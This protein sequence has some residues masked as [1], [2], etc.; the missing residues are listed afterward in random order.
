MAEPEQNN[1]YES[2]QNDFSRAGDAARQAS[3][4]PKKAVR[5]AKT[6]GKAAKA[7]AKAAG[8]AAKATAKATEKTAQVT[9]K[10]ISAVASAL[11]PLG[12]AIVSVLLAVLIVV[13][14]LA[15]YQRQL[16]DEN[17]DI[18]P[19]GK[20]ILSYFERYVKYGQFDVSTAEKEKYQN[21]YYAV[22]NTDYQ[23]ELCSLWKLIAYE[24]VS[25][26]VGWMQTNGY[27]DD[28]WNTDTS[29]ETGFGYG[30][31]AQ[32]HFYSEYL[33]FYED[34]SK[35][36]NPE[37]LTKCRGADGSWNFDDLVTAYKN[38]ISLSTGSEETASTSLANGM[39]YKLH[40]YYTNSMFRLCLDSLV[41]ENTN[42]VLE[43]VGDI[44]AKKATEQGVDE[45]SSEYQKIKSDV[46]NEQFKKIYNRACR[47]INS[48]NYKCTFEANSSDTVSTYREVSVREYIGGKDEKESEKEGTPVYRTDT[49]TGTTS[50]G[51]Y[52]RFVSTARGFLITNGSAQEIVQLAIQQIGNNYEPYCR[53]MNGGV[54]TDWCAFFC[55][56]LLKHCNVDLSN[57]GYAGGCTTWANQANEKGIWRD[58]RSGYT[59]KA[60]DFIF[61][62][63]GVGY[64]YHVGIVTY[65]EGGTITTVEG[66]SGSSSASPY[67]LGSSVTQNTYSTSSDSIAGYISMSYRSTYSGITGGNIAFTSSE[68]ETLRNYAAKEYDSSYN[69]PTY[70][71]SDAE[72]KEVARVVTGEFGE[73]K[74][75][76]MLIA[77]CIRDGLYS[78]KIKRSELMSLGT[79]GPRYDAYFSYH[80]EPYEDAINAVKTIF[81]QG[82]YVVHHKILYMYATDLCTSEWH[83]TQHFILQ[84]LTTRFF[85]EW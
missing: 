32:T 20:Q 34:D 2:E 23:D 81:M 85:D 36:T 75:G 72:I 73:D 16:V 50:D 43:S 55:G 7:T 56:W 64:C 27:T 84:H 38:G 46:E 66:N 18:T 44:V 61:W 41:D 70:Q 6:T 29:A 3:E 83:E 48:D 24:N 15:R 33:R 26:A 14:A 22:E 79:A 74:I 35:F 67:Y 71:L 21:I 31:T 59:P 17:D 52:N 51:L 5:A 30:S 4:I 8:K 49:L 19:E 80:G 57:V 47:L 45:E 65:E 10:I 68:Q 40:Y 60:G 77:Q 58:A 12:M 76:M 39:C 82:Q 28:A 53:E 63:T 9:A 13:N 62:G 25:Y 1:S 11:G 69:P 78:G 42:Q 54:G 37:G